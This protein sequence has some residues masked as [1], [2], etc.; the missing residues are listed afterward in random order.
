MLCR[1]CRP[2]CFGNQQCVVIVLHHCFV[3]TFRLA[4]V[5]GPLEKSTNSYDIPN[6][7]KGGPPYAN[8]ATWCVCMLLAYGSDD[9]DRSSS[10]LL[11]GIQLD[12][13][14]HGMSRIR[15]K[16]LQVGATFIERPGTQCE[17]T[18][19]QDINKIVQNPTYWKRA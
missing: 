11:G 17:A 2:G 4:W 5:I 12:G 8:A 7:G 16:F 10:Q 3:L 9:T 13:S 14:L 1:S 19:G 18:A 6:S 15:D